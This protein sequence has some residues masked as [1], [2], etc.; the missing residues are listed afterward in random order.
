MT[1]IFQIDLT[2]IASDFVAGRLANVAAHG[3]HLRFLPLDLVGGLTT[4]FVG[5][6][7]PAGRVAQFVHK[8]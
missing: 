8:I 1:V 4:Q 5:S 7:Y 2:A 6:K 3:T